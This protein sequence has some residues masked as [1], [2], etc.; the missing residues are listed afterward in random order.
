MK[1]AGGDQGEEATM[2]E[3]LGDIRKGRDGPIARERS[4]VVAALF[5]SGINPTR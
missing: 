3:N 4:G 2:Q 5:L 1:N